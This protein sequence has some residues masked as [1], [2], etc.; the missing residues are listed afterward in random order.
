[1]DSEPRIQT[2]VNN[3]AAFTASHSSS[4]DVYGAIDEVAIY[5]RALSAAEIA[6]QYE[7]LKP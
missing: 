6:Y 4:Y 3:G 2:I 5:G 7:A 1:M